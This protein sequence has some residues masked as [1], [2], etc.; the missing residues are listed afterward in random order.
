MA[1]QTEKNESGM[2][3]LV[4]AS[5]EGIAVLNTKGVVVFANP[6]AEALLGKPSGGALGY[7]LGYPSTDDKPS[8]I[9]NRRGESDHVL[10]EMRVTESSWEDK[11]PSWSTC[12][13]SL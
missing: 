9:N 7:C 10:V 11:R 5:I 13:M 12:T 8:E 4:R 1:H 6:A 2:A 3:D